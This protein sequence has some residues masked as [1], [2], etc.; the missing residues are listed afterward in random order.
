MHAP[1]GSG[2]REMAAH[3]SDAWRGRP[4]QAAWPKIPRRGISLRQKPMLGSWDS[5]DP[6][7]LRIA[8]LSPRHGKR[9]GGVSYPVSA[10]HALTLNILCR[11]RASRRFPTC[12]IRGGGRHPPN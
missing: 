4:E 10:P 1:G 6:V 9:G 11:M 7:C 3:R 8:E 12:N 5:S 2:G